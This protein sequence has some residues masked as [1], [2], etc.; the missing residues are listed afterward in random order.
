MLAKGPVRP[1]CICRPAYRRRGQAR[2]YRSM[3]NCGSELARE[4]AGTAAM[5][6]SPRLSSSRASA[7]LQVQRLTCGSEL[8]RERA[9]AAAMH[10]SPG[11]LS[12]RASALLQVSAEL[13]GGSLLAKGPVRPQCIWRLAYRRRGQARSYRSALNLW[14][15]ACSRKGQYGRNASVARLIVVAGKRAPAGQHRTGG[16]E[17]ARERASTAAMHLSPGLSSSRASALLQVNA[18]LVGESL[19]RERASTAAMPLSP[20]LSS[21]RASALLQVNAEPV[22]ASLLAKGPVRPQCICR[23]AYRRR[24]QARSYRATPYLRERACSRKGQYGRS[25]CK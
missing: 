13:V 10:L 21:S 14:E 8:A 7:L 15:R 19:A 20:G 17:L 4:R 22:G 12:S 24:G 16:R 3:P 23:P 6:L 5:H 18:E 2:S 9:S 1:Q 25:K 11:L